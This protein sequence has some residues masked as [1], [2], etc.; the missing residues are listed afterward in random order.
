MPLKVFIIA[1]EISGDAL[2]AKLIND[3]KDKVAD[4]EFY[5]VGGEQMERQGFKSLFPMRELSVMG[6]FEILPKLNKIL[7]RISQTIE[8]IEKINPDIVV[9]ID[10]PGFA[11]RVMRGVRK[12]K[13]VSP[14]AVHYVAPTVWA[15]KPER[16]A[17]VA[18]LYDG[19]ICLLPFEPEYFLKEGMRA[20]FTG[21]PA[22][23][24]HL[25]VATG[26]N[27]RAELGIADDKNVV[28]VL[29][30]SRMG[31]L[32]QTGPILHEAMRLIVEQYGAD[33]VE[34]VSLTLPHLKKQAQNLLEG[35]SCKTHLVTD[36]S[37]KWDLFKSMDMA[38]A[39]SG[40]VGLE[41]ALAGVPHVI[42]YKANALTAKIVAS[43]LLIDHVHL[44][45][46]LMDKEIVPEFL[47]REC[48]AKNIA[49]VFI[50][51]KD[52]LSG[53][54]HSFSKVRA[55]LQPA[56]GETPADFVVNILEN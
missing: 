38:V 34:I 26:K 45:N 19:M 52:R 9:T 8:N 40:T 11:F 27:I 47:Q 35:L 31:E 50:E 6:I 29:F 13:R 39:T 48:T 17:K 33:N 10:S 54:S 42:G 24:A 44:V 51:H 53:Q 4:V 23:G 30:G 1:G 15:W 43:Q 20:V 16:A 46:I 2:G 49:S 18:K 36:S 55:M 28:G 14:K 37:R 22:A 25:D 12:N 5:G 21:H 56:V 41:L 7:K 32:N 3:L